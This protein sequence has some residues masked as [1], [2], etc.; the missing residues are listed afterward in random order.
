MCGFIYFVGIGGLTEMFQVLG[1]LIY[2][3]SLG[4]SNNFDPCSEFTITS[5]KKHQGIE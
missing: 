3:L 4:F 2:M 5:P 1:H